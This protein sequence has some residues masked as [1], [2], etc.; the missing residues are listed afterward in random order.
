V[1]RGWT[2]S[3]E[4]ADALVSEAHIECI[5]CG[6]DGCAGCPSAFCDRPRLVEHAREHMHAGCVAAFDR[7]MDNAA[8]PLVV[9]EE[10]TTPIDHEPMAL[11]VGAR[12]R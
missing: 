3:A 5:E 8:I 9:D 12:L 6:E 4:T 2:M 1:S 10:E 11:V 7:H